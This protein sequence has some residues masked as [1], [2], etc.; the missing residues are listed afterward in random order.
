MADTR[1]LTCLHCGQSNRLPVDRLGQSPKCGT[2]GADMMPK[3]PV[4]V[5]FQILQKA[6]RTDQIPLVVDF[7]APWCGPCRQMAPEFE[8]AAAM[9]AGQVR[10]AKIDTEK[11][12][13]ASTKWNIRGIPAFIMFQSGKE[14]ARLAGARPASQLV[15][16]VRQG[17]Q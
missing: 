6:A 14:K 1:I 17:A 9:L 7:W 5:D 8:K 11:E 3:K 12:P 13:Q 16:W 15:D 2:C 4:P 10:L